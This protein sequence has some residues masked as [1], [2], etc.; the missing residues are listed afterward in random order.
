MTEE[1]VNTNT[2][3]AQAGAYLVHQARRRARYALVFFVLIAAFCLIT[4]LNINIGNI[5][6]PL[7]RIVE[8]LFT[9]T[10]NPT[11]LLR[12]E[13][14]PRYPLICAHPVSPGRT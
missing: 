6:I 10:G 8:I 4:V 3:P 9:K 5:P 13:V 11:V 1:T 2:A 7:K 14:S 12:I